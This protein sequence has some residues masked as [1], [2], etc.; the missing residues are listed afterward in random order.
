MI[1]ITN[2]L[3]IEKHLDGIEAVIFDLDDT[4]YSEKEYVRSGYRAIAS[5]LSQ[6][7]NAE[8]ELWTAF[9]HGQNAIDTVLNNNNI[10]SDELKEKCLKI[11]RFHVPE[12]HLYSGVYDM[13]ISLKNNGF[14]LGIITDG[15]PEG[16]HNKIDVLGLEN[17][18]DEI[19]ITDEL[20]GIQ[21]RK[22]NE[23]SFRM[24]QD[25]MNIPFENMVYIGDNIKKDFIAPD[26]LGMRS[27][28]FRNSDGLYA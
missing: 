6:L 7:P 21:C 26:K 18:V 14:R 16:Q 17:I 2:I 20:G 12:I 8:E 13:L 28:Y 4:L 5:I 24:M 3:D 25:K 10:Y 9:K 19:I 1:E 15:R 27:I 11:Y 22:P 23:I